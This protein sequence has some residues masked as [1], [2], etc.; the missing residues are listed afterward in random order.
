MTY[1]AFV[2]SIAMALAIPC[3]IAQAANVATWRHASKTDF[4]KAD[5]SGVVVG[6]DGDLTLGR[7]VKS[8]ADLKAASV[9]DLVRTK[10]GKT[11]AAT[12]L[13][14]QVVQ[15]AADGKLT[16]VWS[17]DALQA[18][19]LAA[20]TDGSL[21]VG[22]GPQ[23]TIYKISP[24][25]KAK[26]FYKTGALYVWDLVVDAAGN[27]YAATGPKGQI[28]KIDPNGQGRVFYEAKAQHVLCLALTSDG[29]LL[30]GGDG[31]GL[32]LAID[33]GGRGRVLYDASENE[34]RSLWVGTTGVIYAGT[35]A[36]ASSSA[37][38]SSSSTSSSSGSSE[39]SKVGT[40]SV[41]RI[42]PSGSVRKVLSAKALVYSVAPSDETSQGDLLAG[43]GADGALYLLDE[44]GRG[45]RQL[46]RLDTELLL[47]LLPDK[48]GPLIVGTG[49]PGKLY[50]L[51]G[52]YR[53]S[54]T[55]ISQPLDAKMAARFGSL[56]W[57]AETPEGTQVTVAVRSGNTQTPDD[58]WS[59]W[60]VEQSDPSKAQADCPAARFIQYR[61]TL[62]TNNP[63][64]SP[65]VR[66][67][68]VRYLTANQAPQLTKL[69]VPHVEEGDGKKLVDKLKITWSATDA[70]SDDL[71]YKV[72]YRKGDWKS[73]VTLK[74]DL[75]AGE[76]EWDVTSAPQ[77]MYRV[78]VTASDQRSNP[79]GE[80]LDSTL[81]SEPFAV[82]RAGPQ[83]VARLSGVKGRV[84]AFDVQ[85]N[86]AISPVVAAAYSLDSD[87]WVNVYPTDGLF[88]ATA[89]R[90]KIELDK[91]S[92]GTHVLVVRVT[93]ASGQIS[94]D[95]VVFE[96][97]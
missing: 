80:S 3:G 25:G 96:V 12:A 55:V 66:S 37:S 16:P 76:Y 9:W 40:N 87:K 54:G 93:D 29:T 60:S 63:K 59:Q 22:T 36:G 34:I 10:Q 72:S 4:E 48:N 28:Y 70:N 91:L 69:T 32:V 46:A 38:A 5:L 58:T 44:D 13:P 15:F 90:F 17:D 47:S 81:V 41:Y 26:E 78:Q 53:A 65:I 68:T 27:A 43:T 50:Q 94:S 20:L 7:Q 92:A 19:S 83:V 71:T 45:E 30:A 39:S 74:D 33:A 1:R 77:G 67:M 49:N 95:D 97:D 89:E 86:D 56:V 51:A 11:Y 42:D 73:W 24:D 64:H 23:G 6:R 88:D 57:R 84:A 2:Y 82:D 21:L 61:L 62:S 31:D 8:L 35:A 85:A 52:T 79:A 14:G 75:T 18:F